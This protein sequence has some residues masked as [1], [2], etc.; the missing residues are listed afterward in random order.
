MT[1][2]RPQTITAGAFIS[3]SGLVPEGTAILMKGASKSCEK[4]FFFS[5]VKILPRETKCDRPPCHPTS[6]TSEGNQHLTL[7]CP[8]FSAF[9]WF[10]LS[11]SAWHAC[12]PSTKHTPRPHPPT[13]EAWCLALTLTYRPGFGRVQ[14][15]RLCLTKTVT[16]D[17]AT[18]SLCGL[19]RVIQRAGL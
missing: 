5:W 2:N 6:R 13:T 9:E 18:Y 11:F 10:Q 14:G 8:C 15:S 1:W 7:I 17:I 3:S 12:L 19:P 16:W 4:I